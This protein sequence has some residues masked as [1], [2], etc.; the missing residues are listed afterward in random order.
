LLAELGADV[1]ICGRRPEP[2]DETRE[3]I[4][5]TTGRDCLT[6]AMN[7]RDTEA[8]DDLYARANEAL[9]HLDL[10]VNNAGGQFP[11]HALD[12]SDKGWRA[13]IDNN[14]N[15]TW[16]MMQR[17]G[18]TFRE[19][20]RPGAIVNIIAP[21]RGMYG[22]AHTVAARAG[23]AELSRNVAVEW[24]PF[25]VR[26]N[27]VLPGSIE[28]RG[29]EVYE[30]AVREEMAKAHPLGHNGAVQDIAEAVVYLASSAGGFITGETLHVD[31]GQQLHGTFWQAGRPEGWEREGD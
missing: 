24:A 31:G 22:L 13:V 21:L 7:I 1:I 11:A 5:R 6:H 29:L 26:V 23:V 12:I 20:G 17:A 10:V 2:L 3:L 8:V 15:G 30:P 9:G 28:T 14:L 4:E 27:C 25:G 18:R 16:N 19:A